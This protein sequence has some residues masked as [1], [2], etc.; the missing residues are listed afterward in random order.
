ME[1]QDTFYISG[2]YKDDK[3]EFLD[4]KVSIYDGVEEEDDDIFYYGLSEQDIIR[5]IE[6]GKNGVEDALEFVITSYN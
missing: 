6:D 5:A 3:S 2:Y 4:Y 1:N